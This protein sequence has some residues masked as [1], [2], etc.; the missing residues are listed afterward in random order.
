MKTGRVL[1]QSSPPSL[2]TD[3][4]ISTQSVDL[5]IRIK[6]KK[7]RIGFLCTL[8]ALWLSI[9]TDPLATLRKIND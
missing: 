7:E 9:R 4:K 5:L 6:S 2:F 1:K 8:Y 3:G